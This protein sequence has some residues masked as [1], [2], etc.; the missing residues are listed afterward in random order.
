MLEILKDLGFNN[1]TVGFKHRKSYRFMKARI[2]IDTW[3]KETYPEAYIEIEVKN[4]DD[5]KTIVDILGINSDSISTL[6]IVELK[7]KLDNI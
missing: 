6:S 1:I 2:D 5:L 7:T 3:D 4:Q